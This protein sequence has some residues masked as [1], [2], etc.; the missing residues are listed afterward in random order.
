MKKISKKYCD[1]ENIYIN[2]CNQPLQSGVISQ[3]HTK[4]IRIYNSIQMCIF[5]IKYAFVKCLHENYNIIYLVRLLK[6]YINMYQRFYFKF[7]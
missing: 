2:A 5:I 7:V 1:R 6:T 3:N 4:S